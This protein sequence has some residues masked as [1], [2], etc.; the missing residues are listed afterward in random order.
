VIAPPL[1]GAG[2]AEVRIVIGRDVDAGTLEVALDGTDVS[3]RFAAADRGPGDA[4]EHTERLAT[5]PIGAGEHELVARARS[6]S[7][8][9]ADR[10]YSRQLRFSAPA[11]LE[12][13]EVG[14]DPDARGMLRSD[15]FRLRLGADA[16]PEALQ[17]LELSCEQQPRPF[18][19][20]LLADR[21]VVVVPRGDL[22]PASKCRLVWRG[23]DGPADW[24]VETGPIG[25]RA[26]VLYD[27]RDSRGLAPF[28]DDF[29]LATNPDDPNESGVRLRAS[30][31]G[32]PEQWLINAL[33]TGV[34]SLDGFS[35]IG[36]FT[37]AMSDPVDVSS[38]PS[39]YSESLGADASVLLFDVTPDDPDFGARIP[40]RIEARSEAIRGPGHH[41]LLL[42]PSVSLEA[43]HRYGIVVTRRVRSADGQPFGPSP[44]FLEV[45]DSN[46]TGTGWIVARARDLLDDVLGVAAH[47]TIPIDRQDVAFAARFSIRGLDG[48][49]ADLAHIRRVTSQA[50][51]PRITE[52]S[53]EPVIDPD[54]DSSVVAIVRGSWDSINW[55]DKQSQLARD[56]ATGLP[57]PTGSRPLRFVMALPRAALTGPV[58][59]VFY[60]HGNPGSAEEEVV[61]HADRYLA[62]AGFAVV[63]FD[64]VLNRQNASPRLSVA[65]RASH[66]AVDIL[67]RIIVSSRMPDYFS[68]TIADQMRFVSV[69]GEL[70]SIGGFSVATSANGNGPETR[71]VFGIDP[72]AS[73]LY[74][75]VSEGAHHGSMLLPFEPRIRAAVLISPGRR[76]SEVLIHQGVEQLLAPLWSLGFRR[77][78]PTDIWVTL[79]LIQMMFDDQ[80]PSNFARFLYR[81][82]LPIEP[83]RRASVLIVEGLDDSFVPNHATNALARD[84]GPVVQLSPPSLPVP[85]LETA[86]GSVAGNVDASTTA[87]LYQF[88]PL[89]V[90]GVA[91]T[92]GC[93]SPPLSERSARE[94]HYCA[95]SAAESIELRLDFFQS[96]LRG[97]PR[98]STPS[99][100]REPSADG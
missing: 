85:G 73:L 28:P 38:L 98:A 10:N 80:D 96:A 24:R 11:G 27:R 97:L 69:I 47:A 60:Q 15:W 45:R 57:V 95:Q 6:G 52:V 83:A 14:P 62:A 74:L 20:H 100:A 77:L 78:G 23:E 26:T 89:G 64:D 21:R 87:A 22:P 94:G 37:V 19:I 13:L 82:P 81:E 86:D 58:P 3:D 50:P 8:A 44:F 34:R 63:G 30:G 49:E 12:V 4:T 1:F 36:H 39:T 25:P 17:S 90:V 93:A 42:F 29:W 92:A 51:P 55:L 56:V 9:A 72:G 18:D 41:A 32:L 33:A 16:T 91:P 75:G 99:S 68:Q 35:P 79:A 53:V 88:V 66:Q 70:A 59:V 5:I 76:Y 31:F 2:T 7:N 48:I 84:L 67:F 65:E 46:P 71:R 54:G 43:H 61:Q 40:F